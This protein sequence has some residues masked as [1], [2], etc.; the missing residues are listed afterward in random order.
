MTDTTTEN[1][2]KKLTNMRYCKR[3][4]KFVEIKYYILRRVERCAECTYPTNSTYHANYYAVNPKELI[5]YE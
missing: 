3:C 4:E 5:S 2:V 1:V